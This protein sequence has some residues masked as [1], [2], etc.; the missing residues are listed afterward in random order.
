MESLTTC[1]RLGCPQDLFKDG[2]CKEMRDSAREAVDME[3]EG[4]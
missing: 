2:W 3:E 1:K 4:K